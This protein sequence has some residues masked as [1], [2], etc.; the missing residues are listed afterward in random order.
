MSVPVISTVASAVALLTLLSRE[1][2]PGTPRK[3][4]TGVTAL[5]II[6]NIALIWVDRPVKITV[7]IYYQG[8]QDKHVVDLLKT[9]LDSHTCTVLEVQQ[10]TDAGKWTVF[11]D[12]KWQIRYFY[13]DDHDRA[14]LVRIIA[15]V[16]VSAQ[17]RRQGVLKRLATEWASNTKMGTVEVWIPALQRQ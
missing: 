13:E 3:I 9:E 16:S 8:L 4:L 12:N 2:K 10:V 17:E 1:L 15:E 6:C 7:R 14:D 5:C 11:S